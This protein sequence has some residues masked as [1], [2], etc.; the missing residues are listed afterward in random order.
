MAFVTQSESISCTT[1]VK[2]DQNIAPATMTITV[3]IR[4][5]KGNEIKAPWYQG[6]KR[7]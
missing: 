2:V 5:S 7:N 1:V 6:I 3:N 4:D